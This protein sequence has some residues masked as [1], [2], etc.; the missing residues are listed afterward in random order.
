MTER[1]RSSLLGLGPRVLG[2]RSLSF[3]DESES[4]RRT[5]LT[6]QFRTRDS[7]RAFPG[8]CDESESSRRTFLIARFRT[9]G[10]RR[11]FPGFCRRE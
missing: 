7:R 9:M 6:A 1:E 3:A 8:F 10:S 4:S 2:E 11:A 5:F